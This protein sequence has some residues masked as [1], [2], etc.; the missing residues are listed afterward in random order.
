MFLIWFFSWFFG[1]YSNLVY[2]SGFFILSTPLSA[3]RPTSLSYLN[4]IPF[5]PFLY[6][7]TNTMV[8]S[9]KMATLHYKYKHS[10]NYIPFQLSLFMM[11]SNTFL[12][13]HF[14]ISLVLSH[15]TSPSNPL[16]WGL[17]FCNSIHYLFIQE[18]RIFYPP[19]T[20][21]LS[22]HPCWVPSMEGSPLLPLYLLAPLPF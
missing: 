19:P 14:Q 2:H 18:C 11:H 21:P 15:F 13:I 6:F 3:S 12:L 8:Y 17:Y 16:L 20:P 5:G 9:Q 22:L 4:T 7:L 10:C 1:F